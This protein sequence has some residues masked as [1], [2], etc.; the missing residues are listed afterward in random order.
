MSKSWAT[1]ARWAA[2]P[3]CCTGACRDRVGG[4]LPAAGAVPELH[5]QLWCEVSH[6]GLEYPPLPPAYLASI[7]HA[8][9]ADVPCALGL[10]RRR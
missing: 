7:D 5:A 6:R 3:A 8:W 1:S 4:R 10:Q 9:P 2:T